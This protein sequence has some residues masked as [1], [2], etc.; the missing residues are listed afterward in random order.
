MTL[1]GNMES[2]PLSEVLQLA[3]RSKQTGLLRVESGASHGNVY[4]NDGFLSY[5]SIGDDDRLGDYLTRSGIVDP[6]Q[7]Y[8]VERGEESIGAALLDGK[9]EADVDRFVADRIADVLV[10]LMRSKHGRFEFTEKIEPMYVTG[11]RLQVDDVMRCVEARAADWAEIESVIPAHD[12]TIH[13]AADLNGRDEI[14]IAAGAWRVIA[15]LA[16]ASTVDGVADASGLSDFSVASTMA[17]LVKQGLLEVRAGAADSG[18]TPLFA[19]SSATISVATAPAVLSPEDRS[20]LEPSD[21]AE[22]VGSVEL[23]K[24]SD[25]SPGP[26]S[27]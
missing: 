26:T 20:G 1:S 17:E 19:A 3:A 4:F 16:T 5:A 24:R 22:D 8:P 27:W 15:A 12:A 25:G 6:H 13:L 21:V 14:T 9:T 18:A 7:W 10:R 23:I 2:F 11:L